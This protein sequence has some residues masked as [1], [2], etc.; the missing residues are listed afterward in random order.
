MPTF[1]YEYQSM[2][3]PPLH[4]AI[5]NGT[6]K[7]FSV[8]SASDAMQRNLSGQVPSG[9]SEVGNGIQVNSESVFTKHLNQY[10]CTA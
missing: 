5:S 10:L 4:S 6:E 1:T 2:H 3:M 7:Q 9:Y 8:A